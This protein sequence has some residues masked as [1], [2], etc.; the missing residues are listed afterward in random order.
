[1]LSKQILLKKS[2]IAILIAGLAVTAAAIVLLAV[3]PFPTKTDGE[4]ASRNIHEDACHNAHGEAYRSE[5]SLQFRNRTFILGRSP[6]R[7]I[8]GAMHYFRVHP[9]HWRDRMMKLK[10]CGMNTLET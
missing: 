10:A 4:N 6:I 2:N 9:D 3:I 7:I 5:G 8:S 1:M